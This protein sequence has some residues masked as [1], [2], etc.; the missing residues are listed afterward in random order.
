MDRIKYNTT[1]SDDPVIQEVVPSVIGWIFSL[2]T[3]TVLF[4]SS[5]PPKIRL[6]YMLPM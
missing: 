2:L 6:P 1:T 3:S 4:G 5:W